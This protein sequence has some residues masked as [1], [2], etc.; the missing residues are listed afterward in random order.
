MRGPPGWRPGRVSRRGTCSCASELQGDVP[1]VVGAS[2]RRALSVA[3]WASRAR[4]ASQ[5]LAATVLIHPPIKQTG[6]C[7]SA[8]SLV[9]DRGLEGSCGRAPEPRRRPR[10]LRNARGRRSSRRWSG[11]RTRPLG[12]VRRVDVGHGGSDPSNVRRATCHRFAGRRGRPAVLPLLPR[13]D[14]GPPRCE[15]RSKK[16]PQPAAC[17]RRGR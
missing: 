13:D 10:R 15:Q 1:R 6:A 2:R 3:A 11:H 7:E 17:R 12:R 5:F 4:V 16:A 14:G 8:P 9:R